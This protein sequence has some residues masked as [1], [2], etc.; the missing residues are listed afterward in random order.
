MKKE[1]ER[2]GRVIHLK[3]FEPSDYQ[4][5]IGWHKEATEADMYSWAGRTFTL[6]VTTSQLEQYAKSA[7]E[8]VLPVKLFTI[9]ETA[10]NEKIGHIQVA[11]MD[12]L[13][14]SAFLN[15]IF[16]RSESRNNGYGLLLMDEM[17]RYVFDTLG[18]HRLSLYVLSNNQKARWLY[19][20]A[21]FKDEGTMRDARFFNGHYLDLHLMSLL[22]TD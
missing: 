2:V 7:A 6:P 16:I 20:K 19:Q 15:R 5:F 3:P 1:K 12:E 17:K 14:R 9:I 10:T 13:N 18:Y 4:A 11:D 8:K 22:S 21:G